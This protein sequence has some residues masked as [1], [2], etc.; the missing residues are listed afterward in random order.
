MG[1]IFYLSSIK[2]RALSKIAALATRESREMA[3]CLRV[4]AEGRARSGADH[5]AQLLDRGVRLVHSLQHRRHAEPRARFRE[6]WI[7]DTMRARRVEQ[8][9]PRAEAAAQVVEVDVLHLRDELREERIARMTIAELR[10]QV[11]RL[12]RLLLIPE[13]DHL[14]LIVGFIAED[15]AVLARAQHLLHPLGLVAA[16]Q[17]QEKPQD[18]R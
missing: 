12:L 17:Q 16:R 3:L 6:R 9:L 1:E 15:G 2:A 10:Q 18:L 5:R 14:Q 11:E 8:R 7:R 13:V 4:G